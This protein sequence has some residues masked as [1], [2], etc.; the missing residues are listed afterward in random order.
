MGWT[1]KHAERPGRAGS[2]AKR[3]SGFHAAAGPGLA[4]T[5]IAAILISA[6]AG[7]AQQR[8]GGDGRAL[9]ANPRS[10]SGGTNTA[11]NQVDYQR[12]NNI[13]TGN[14]SGGRGFRGDVD[15]QAPN[16]FRDAIGSD[17]LFRF[18]A[19]SLQSSP[20]QPR[21]SG[22]QSVFRSFS[23]D[24]GTGSAPRSTR[25]SPGGTTIY[26]PGA[27]SQGQTPMTPGEFEAGQQGDGPSG[28]DPGQPTYSLSPLL[29]VRQ[30]AAPSDG[31]AQPDTGDAADSIVPE[32]GEFTPTT[33]ES[34]SPAR[35]ATDTSQTRRDMRLRPRRFESEDR[36]RAMLQQE[37]LTSER[38]LRQ[39]PAS[40]LGRQLQAQLTRNQPRARTLDQRVSRMQQALFNQL[41]Q[42]QAD[43]ADRAYQ[44]VLEAMKSERPTEPAAAEG[45]DHQ[46]DP[47]AVRIFE[48]MPSEEQLAKA[49]QA[50]QQALAELYGESDA[51]GDQ[52]GQ[53]RQPGEQADQPA[54][55]QQPGQGEQGEQPQ[56]PGQVQLPGQQQPGDQQQQAGEAE[57]QPGQQGESGSLDQTMAKLDYDAPALETLVGERNT[58]VDRLLK[59]AEQQMGQGKF[60]SAE[61]TYRQLLVDAP[62][63]PLVR[64]GLIHA[65]LGAGLIRSAALNMRK[66]FNEHPELI[67]TRY[68]KALL[69]G[70]D[71]LR[72][73]QKELQRMIQQQQASTQPGMMLAYLGYQTD[74]RQ[75]IRYGLATAEAEKPR[76]PLL[77]VLRRIWLEQEPAKGKGQDAGQAQGQGGQTP[78]QD[79][80]TK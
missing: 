23:G 48:Q 41:E 64:A 34:D 59:K 50:R 31:P 67:A 53:D 40:F 20:S 12:R 17:D 74:A 49:E 66:L 29:G 38:L 78:D 44:N 4:L 72:W 46:P 32:T 6:S 18:R 26:D 56:R 19:Q 11:E 45:E 69:P 79:G 75:L 57:G 55:Q 63:R 62:N 27:F 60:F 51:D 80:Q 76:D 36:T 71:R 1:R 16:E 7:L 54:G 25:I 10:G 61:D 15:Y 42:R 77:P 14:V 52:P 28:I 24:P 58:R 73:L 65:Q 30:Q 2:A 21:Q 47:F 70:K 43:P 13:I 8:A 37:G 33:P 5:A 39:Q 35:D 22:G 68:D 9:D 3:L